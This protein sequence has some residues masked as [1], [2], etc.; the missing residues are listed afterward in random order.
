MVCK[1]RISSPNRP[2]A[3]HPF[4]ELVEC[5]ASKSFLRSVRSPRI[6]AFTFPSLSLPT[7]RRTASASNSRRPIRIVPDWT[8]NA[9]Q[10]EHYWKPTSASGDLCCL[11]EECIV[12]TL[13]LSLVRPGAGGLPSIQLVPPAREMGGGLHV[14]VIYLLRA[15]PTFTQ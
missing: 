3:G 8:E 11:N 10:G 7:S 4:S 15:C 9:V 2:F 5:R 14:S 13:S 12:S 6:P 1:N